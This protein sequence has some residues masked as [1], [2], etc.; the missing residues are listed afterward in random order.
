M[1]GVPGLVVFVAML[2]GEV[3]GDAGG[4]KR[5]GEG[6]P[7]RTDFGVVPAMAKVEGELSL[8]KAV[9]IA[10][11]QNPDVARALKDIQRTQGQIV[12]ARAD[13]L[14]RVA[15]TAS[16]DYTDPELRYSSLAPGASVLGGFN[17]ASN[18][19][20][21]YQNK[22]WRVELGVRQNV[23][24]GGRITAQREVARIARDEAYYALRATIDRTISAVRV[25]YSR[26]LA[27][28][29]MVEVSEEAVRLADEQLSNATSRFNAGTVPRF[30]VLRAEV[31]VANVKPALIRSKN[32]YL[33]LRLELAKLLGL[34]PSMDGGALLRCSG[35][36]PDVSGA[37]DLSAAVQLARARRPDLKQ[38]RER[39]L[40]EKESIKVALAGKKP[41]VEVNGGL[42]MQ[43]DAWD[44]DTEIHGWF[45]GVTGQWNLFDGMLSDGRAAQARARMDS[46]R[47]AYDDLVRQAELEVQKAYADMQQARETVTSQK[48]N[49][50][51]ALEALRLA[52]E[53]LSA[54]AGT[55]LEVLDAQVAL[56][57][58]RTN[59]LQG[60]SDFAR[61]QA[62]FDRATAAD[63]VF[64]DG[65]KDPLAVLEKKVLS[66]SVPLRSEVPRPAPVPVSEPVSE[67][68]K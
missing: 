68:G 63:T 6:V 57:R 50:E 40:S 30:N 39:I 60:R 51:Q 46:A 2:L 15:M 41:T 59:E 13:A 37:P 36:L 1:R 4:G 66:V 7:V 34:T 5:A 54:G 61:A 16:F 11:R 67:G 22:Q 47:I 12:E 64:D 20:I 26:V 14:P 18:S 9:E 53:R 35:E 24:S 3:R 62:E 27:A 49:V 56:T 25:M 17:R 8:E 48:K 19:L 55:Q 31:E 65:F 43:R 10:L 32:E 29:A 58:A 21:H 33:I 52:K 23:Y 42:R 28:R 38:Q 44:I 45:F